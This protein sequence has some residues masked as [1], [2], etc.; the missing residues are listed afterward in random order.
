MRSLQLR[1]GSTWLAGADLVDDDDLH[2]AEFTTPTGDRPDR[3]RH[4]YSATWSFA[5]NSPGTTP[6]DRRSDDQLAWLGE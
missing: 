5:P 4:P 2:T 3:R 1:Q 6:P